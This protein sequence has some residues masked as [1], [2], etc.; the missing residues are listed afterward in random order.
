MHAVLTCSLRVYNVW[1]MRVYIHAILG[2][3]NN[4]HHS[5]GCILT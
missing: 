4:R 1:R 5:D 2:T 3:Y